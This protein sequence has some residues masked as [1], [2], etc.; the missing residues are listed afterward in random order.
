[1]YKMQEEQEDYYK[2]RK[3]ARSNQWKN[4][5]KEGAIKERFKAR[6]KEKRKKE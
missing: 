6:G 3:K 2:G 5:K 1:M 4:V